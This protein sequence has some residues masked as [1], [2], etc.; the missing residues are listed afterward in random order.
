MQNKNPED[1]MAHYTSSITTMSYKVDTRSKDIK[2]LKIAKE[3][4]RGF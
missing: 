4:L 3:R 2:N 1:I